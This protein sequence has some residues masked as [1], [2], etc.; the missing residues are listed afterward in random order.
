MEQSIISK[1]NKSSVSLRMLYISIS[2]LLI[3][4]DYLGKNIVHLNQDIRFSY[5]KNGFRYGQMGEE[6]SRDIIDMAIQVS[7]AINSSVRGQE[8]EVHD[9]FFSNTM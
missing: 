6:E 9:S 2:F 7:S 8:K 4:L 1:N 5:L 3:N